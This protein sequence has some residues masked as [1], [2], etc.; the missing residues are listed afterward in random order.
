MIWDRLFTFRT[1][2]PSYAVHRK[3]TVTRRWRK[4]F[5]AEPKVAE[6]LILLGGVLL[7]DPPNPKSPPSVEQLAYEAGR[8]DFALQ[9]L[10]M[11]GL[12]PWQLNQMMGETDA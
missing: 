4:I 7:L 1:L 10:A 2:F 5:E 6:D 11:G 9:L 8:R 3:I 12:S